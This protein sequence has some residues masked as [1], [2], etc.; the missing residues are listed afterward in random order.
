MIWD[1]LEKEKI[2]SY[3][4]VRTLCSDVLLDLRVLTLAIRD[5]T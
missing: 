1:D 2:G 4:T 3:I 5:I